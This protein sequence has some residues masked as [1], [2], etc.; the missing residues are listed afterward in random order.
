MFLLPFILTGVLMLGILN[1]PYM[2]TLISHTAP[3]T[4]PLLLGSLLTRRPCSYLLPEAP[5]KHRFSDNYYLSLPPPLGHNG[6]NDLV[7]L[8]L[9]QLGSDLEPTSRHAQ[10]FRVVSLWLWSLLPPQAA[11]FVSTVLTPR[12]L[13]LLMVFIWVLVLRGC[14]ALAIN[15]FRVPQPESPAVEF[16]E[17]LHKKVSCRL[18]TYRI[19]AATNALY[20]ADPRTSVHAK[21]LV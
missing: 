12:R 21:H 6:T 13:E 15:K 3:H 17:S 9:A 11:L 19:Y 4:G 7:A 8:A 16:V 14:C 1:P 5:Y 2:G 10:G 18:R 20:F